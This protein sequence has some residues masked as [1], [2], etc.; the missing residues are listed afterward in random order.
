MSV[1]LV[2]RAALALGPIADDVVFVGAAV[3]PLLITDPAAPAPMSTV[4]VD[5][6]IEV[7]SQ[8]ALR[9][10]ERRLEERGFAHDVAS[11]V[12]CRWRYRDGLVLDA[13][14]S[15][16]SLQGFGSRWLEGAI[17]DAWIHHLAGGASIRVMSAPAFLAAKLDAFDQRGNGDYLGA[18]GFADAIALI[19][20]RSGLAD[21][22]AGSSGERRAFL[23]AR[24]ASLIGDPG[25]LDGIRGALAPDSASQ[26]RVQT[27]ILP[28]LRLLASA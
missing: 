8:L 16:Q 4:D 17:V 22:V 19:D 1:A 3:L 13:I 2:E 11:G 28:V 15:D 25:A 14:P 7:R 20:G 9:A 24:C 27:V 23:A 12:I 18:R 21:E 26:A 10:F 6:V 5:V